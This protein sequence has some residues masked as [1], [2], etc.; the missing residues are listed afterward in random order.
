MFVVVVCTW[1]HRHCFLAFDVVSSLASGSRSTTKVVLMSHVLG[2]KSNA[3]IAY[4]HGDVYLALSRR[5][6]CFAAGL[7]IDSVRTC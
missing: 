2:G 5:V 3:S 7:P 6:M 4:G 1:R